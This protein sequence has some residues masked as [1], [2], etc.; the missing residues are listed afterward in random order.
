MNRPTFQEKTEVKIV[1]HDRVAFY[2]IN[3][4][5]REYD[6]Y[7]WRG[8]V[9]E[10]IGFDDNKNEIAKP[11]T[12]EN[13]PTKWWVNVEFISPVDGKS[14][15]VT[16]DNWSEQLAIVQKKF[17]DIENLREFDEVIG[18]KEDGTD[19][20]RKSN[21]GAFDVGDTIQITTKIDGANASISWDETTQKLEIFSRTNLL[22]TSNSLRGFYDYIKTQVEPKL[23]ECTSYTD[24]L[25]RL[26]IFGEWEIKHSIKYNND[27][28]NKWYIYDIWDKKKQT[29]C[30]Q[31]FVKEV[32]DI[33][34]FNYIEELYNGPFI[35]WEHC[36]SFMNKSTAYGP[37]Q[38]GIVVKNQTA[39]FRPENRFPAYLKI[40]NES[41]K[42]TMKVKPPKE[43]NPEATARRQRNIEL[44][45]SIVT[46][47][48]VKK[49]LLKLIDEGI[50]PENL[51]PKDMGLV[52]K[53]LPK[54]VYEDVLKEEMETV[55]AIG[56]NASKIISTSV[57]QIARKIIIG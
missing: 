3:G 18:Q 6:M 45:N 35:S 39:L 28:Y 26:V 8:K 15:R 48:R 2:R 29:Y 42:E 33:F 9:T 53:N 57:A 40:V 12:P 38:E 51:T 20:V 5:D 17:I 37:D 31:T 21:T 25:N 1:S 41:F 14:C 16:F 50:I 54:R 44:A 4:E 13:Y 36:R 27:V 32:C 30:T 24:T 47:A 22:D 46:E 19:I 11:Y 10:I 7:G 56:E 34:G 55:K 52:M 23:K 43:I 49:I